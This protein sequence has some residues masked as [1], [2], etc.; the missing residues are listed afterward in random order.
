M[1]LGEYEPEPERVVVRMTEKAFRE[2]TTKDSGDREE[3]TS[4]MVRDSNGGKPRFDLILP[5]GVPFE[6]QLLTRI[7]RLYE[8]GAI[9]YTPR[10]WEKADSEEELDRA[11]ESAFRHFMQ[12]YC[13]E[14]DEDH[15]AAVFFNIN[16]VELIE[17]KLPQA[18][19]NVT[20]EAEGE[21]DMHQEAEKGDTW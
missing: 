6:A 3:F 14:R 20:T 15:G 16:E 18:A 4:G 7:A 10:N 12:W 2:W 9:K 17:R 5:K 1:A 13:G 21:R 8:R 11:K 19:L